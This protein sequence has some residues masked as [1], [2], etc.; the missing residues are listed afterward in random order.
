MREQPTEAFGPYLLYEK[1]GSGGMATVHRAKKRGIEG[2]E[3]PV[4]LKRLLPELQ[5]NDEF[6][7]SF[8]REAR[9]AAQLRHQNIAQTYDLGRVDGTY[10]IA[11]ELVP[12]A[13]LRQILRHTAY[14]TGPMPV[15][16]VLNVLAQL[17]DAL[18]YAHTFKDE[19]GT[20]LGL[21][22]RDVS[23]AN[24]M[25]GEDGC[26]KLV[27]FGI[28]KAT[29]A[30]WQTMSGQLKGKFA[31]MAPEML[32]GI[33]DARADL[34]SLGIVAYELLTAQPLFS[35][36][37]DI[38]TL[39]RVKVW[40]PPNP[41]TINRHCNKEVD[42]VV[43]TALAKNP[44]QR[45]QTAAQLR[46]ALEAMSRMPGMNASRTDVSAW[47]QWAFTQPAGAR[48]W[49]ERLS[50]G[51]PDIVIE[52]PAAPN[53]AA[54]M[55]PP[56]ELHARQRPISSAPPPMGAPAPHVPTM[57]LPA[58]QVPPAS[59]QQLASSAARTLFVDPGAGMPSPQIGTGTAQWVPGGG[60][61][62]PRATP[63]N[64]AAARP[65]MVPGD[66]M[67]M[68]ARPSAN[69]VTVPA[70]FSQPMG[71]PHGTPAAPAIP[72]TGAQIA[73][74]NYLQAMAA[75]NS[76]GAPPM[77]PAAREQAKAMIDLPPPPK[78]G[79]LGVLLLI[80]V[81]GLAATGGYFVV[82]YLTAH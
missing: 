35:A 46:G 18:D 51:D 69:M 27:D 77:T 19:N 42:M 80:L 64:E 7:R 75:Y 24:V 26:V 36:S 41:S 13:D 4:A 67:Q 68:P 48:R 47:I 58:A 5:V 50:T 76:G 9:L 31:Y 17:C 14:S 1:L 73:D 23:P 22:H 57:P 61:P 59:P 70:P 29:A 30:N 49:D 74:P 12:G 62:E 79:G 39:K 3:R 78:S 43:M 8:V 65:T 40:T 38:E 52:R 55:V 71:T 2:V 44:T 60:R 54:T 53:V 34:F 32:E 33:V 10:Y 28:T 15:P 81:C 21:V 20:P 66:Y 72:A 25:I 82:H 11:M 16:L 6:V 56:E 37:D 63:Y 45:W